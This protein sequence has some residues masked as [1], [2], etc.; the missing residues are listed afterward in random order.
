MLMMMM[1]IPPGE[2]NPPGRLTPRVNTSKGCKNNFLIFLG[3]L[4]A[5]RHTLEGAEEGA[6]EDAENDAE[7]AEESAKAVR[8]S[9]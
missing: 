2:V 8:F 7:E 9:S 6:K 1:M 5:A 4:T 3:V